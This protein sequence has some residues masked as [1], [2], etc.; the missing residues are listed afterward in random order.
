MTAP[1]LKGRRQSDRLL[2][3]LV[4]LKIAC[5]TRSPPSAQAYAGHLN[6]CFQNIRKFTEGSGLVPSDL[7][8]ERR[9]I[10]DLWKKADILPLDDR[11]GGRSSNPRR[12]QG[13]DAR[14]V[15]L[16]SPAPASEPGPERRREGGGFR[17]QAHPQ[18]SIHQ[19]SKSRRRSCPRIPHRPYTPPQSLPRRGAG[20]KTDLALVG[21][22]RGAWVS[23]RAMAAWRQAPHA[24]RE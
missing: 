12:E 18:P 21:K 14:V 6:L 11:L 7:E 17:D 4:S 8:T 1:Q 24:R 9:K 2:D 10:N 5:P 13:R 20:L 23:P 15:P 19:A 16:R 22:D 3:K